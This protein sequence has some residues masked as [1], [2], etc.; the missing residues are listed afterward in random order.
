ML[1]TTPLQRNSGGECGST[2]R[3]RMDSAVRDLVRHTCDQPKRT[4]CTP[5]SP[6]I[7][8]ACVSPSDSR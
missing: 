5:V 2:A 4:R 3:R 8:G 1:R 6:S 7:T